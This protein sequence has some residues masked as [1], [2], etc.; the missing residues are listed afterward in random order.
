MP[1]E[2]K[3]LG[4]LSNCHIMVFGLNVEDPDITTDGSA[5]YA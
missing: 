3:L 2:T 1:R 4:V 5:R